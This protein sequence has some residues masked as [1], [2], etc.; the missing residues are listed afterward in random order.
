MDKITPKSLRA[1]LPRIDIQQRASG[2][3]TTIASHKDGRW[4][5]YVGSSSNL[6]ER[7]KRHVFDIQAVRNGV[8]RS[9][10]QHC[11]RIL[12]KNGWTATYHALTVFTQSTSYIWVHIFETVLIVLFKSIEPECRGFWHTNACAEL[13][14]KL[15]QHGLPISCPSVD[16]DCN[17]LS[18]PVIG[19][20]R[21][22]P[23]K[24]GFNGSHASLE[25]TCKQCGAQSSGQWYPH[26]KTRLFES[27]ICR[28]CYRNGKPR[29]RAQQE[30]HEKKRAF[31]ASHPVVGPCGSCGQTENTRRFAALRMVLCLREIL[32]YRRYGRLKPIH[33]K[34]RSILKKKVP[35]VDKCDSCGEDSSTASRLC[36]HQ[37]TGVVLC[38]RQIIHWKHHQYSDPYS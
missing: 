4:A 2:V 7:I 5:L 21:C 10:T 1:G 30:W 11:H 35:V 34:A 22:L 28:D 16:E 32:Y 33:D 13:W 3:Y 14:D 37:G 24:A 8:T 12:A 31:M 17:S 25:R 9:G 23:I 36:R 6:P 29:T 27:Y 38:T 18:P 19:L 20:N 15:V 26:D